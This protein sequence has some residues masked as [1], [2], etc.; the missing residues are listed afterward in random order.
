[1]EV[2]TLLPLAQAELARKRSTL[3]V[4]AFAGKALSARAVAGTDLLEAM[5][6]GG[7]PEMI[8]RPDASR[9][10]AWARDYARAVIS[11]DVRDIA[12]VIKLDEMPRL[13]R[14]LAHHAGQLLN[15][16][17]L[18]GQLGLDAKTVRRY[19]GILEQVFLVRRIE[20]WFANR[21]SR[22]I[23][24]PKVQFFDSGLLASLRGASTVALGSDRVALGALFETFVFAEVAKQISWGDDEI[25]VYHYRDKDQR[26]VDLVLERSD[27]AVVG[28]EIKAAASV[29]DRD[30]GGL[31]RLATAC[32]DRFVQGLVAYD[33][34]IA[35]PFGDRMHAMPISALWR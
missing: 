10:K 4:D 5:L 19:I 35:V 15:A 16:S 20:P 2:V 8:A 17:E 9:R 12:E 26:E 1:M 13:L 6:V 27:G 31:R 3:L 11:R 18:G 30:L 28:I 34:D 7:F 33:G 22:V 21:L 24:S 29:S 25:N 32:G 14:A 23:K